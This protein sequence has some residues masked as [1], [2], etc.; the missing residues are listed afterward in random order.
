M[1]ITLGVED[2]LSELVA[3]RLLTEYAPNFEVFE[4]LGLRGN[5][6][7][8]R[9][10]RP[11]NAIATRQR[12]ALIITDLDRPQ[13]CPPALLREWASG[14]TLSPNLLIRVAVLEIEAWLLADQAG[15]AQW[16]G[17]SANRIPANPETVLDPKRTL[18]ELANRSR[19]R[20]LRTAIVPRRGIGTHQIGPG[21]DQM[22]GEFALQH[23]NTEAARSTARSLDKAIIRIGELVANYTP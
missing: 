14:L 16:L 17:I 13:S 8:R 19:N 3:R 10:L 18:V 23:W 22:V 12:P 5:R 9:S 1:F 21:Y 4:T 7:L 2:R 11:L 15:I 20:D 6:Q